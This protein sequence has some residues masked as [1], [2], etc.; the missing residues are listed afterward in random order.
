MTARRCAI[1]D[2]LKPW[3]CRDWC[4]MHYYRWKRHGD[5]LIVRRAFQ[6]VSLLDR[7][8]KRVEKDPETGC[9]LW[10]GGK[11]PGGYALFSVNRKT[12]SA[13]RWSYEHHVGAI[14]EGLQIDHLCVTPSCVNPEHLE[15]VTA[16]ENIRRS[17]GRAAVTAR[18]GVCAE[19]HA[20]TEENTYTAPSGLRR[21]RACRRAWH[22][23][24][25]QGVSA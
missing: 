3:F 14:P 8:M 2:C 12:V 6:D 23:A 13:H 16:Q 25:R 4:E 11:N 15:P 9:W 22:A 21:C 1:A 19:G 18:T 24:R 7:F 20:M 17:S 5:P 10:T